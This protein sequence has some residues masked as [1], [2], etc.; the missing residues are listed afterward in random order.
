[1]LQ[2]QDQIERKMHNTQQPTFKNSFGATTR[3]LHGRVVAPS[4]DQITGAT[5]GGGNLQSQFDKTTEMASDGGM[6]LDAAADD[7]SR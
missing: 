6:L 1:M 7:Y 3:I 2:I 5:D 4:K